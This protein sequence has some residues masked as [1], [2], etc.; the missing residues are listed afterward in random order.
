MI[1]KTNSWRELIVMM[2]EYDLK[3]GTVKRV[4]GVWI[5][6]GEG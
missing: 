2:R 4:N 1:I 6:K 5:F 3:A